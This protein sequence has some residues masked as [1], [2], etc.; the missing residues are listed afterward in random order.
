MVNRALDY[1][2]NWA[3]YK[4]DDTESGIKNESIIIQQLK[5]FFEKDKNKRGYIKALYLHHLLDY[6]KETYVNVNNLDLVFEKFLQ[7]KVVVEM[8]DSEGKRIVF[9]EDIDDIFDLVRK[10]KEELFKDLN[11]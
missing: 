7:S 5:Y 9:Q 2:F 11:L 4:Q 10:N 3:F 1:G 6:F 8:N